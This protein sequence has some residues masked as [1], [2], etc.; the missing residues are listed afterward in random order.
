MVPRDMDIASP[1]TGRLPASLL[2]LAIASFGI[3]TTE[4]IIMGLLPDVA[5]DLG[6]SVPRAGFLVSGYAYGVAFGAPLVAI[7]TARLPR[8]GALLALMGVFVLGNLS[9][10]SA[11]TYALLMAARVLT[12]LAHG[13]F[14]GIGSVVARDLVAPHRRGRAVAVMFSGLTLANVLGVPFGTAL[15]QAMGW[16]FPF[17]VVVGIGIA[18]AGAI[19]AFVPSGLAGANGVAAEIRALREPRVLWPMAISVLSSVSLFSVFTYIAPLLEDVSGLAP[20]AVTQA[21]L[22]FGLGI[23][24]GNIA[25]GRLADWRLVETVRLAFLGVA[26]ALAALTVTSHDGTAAVVTLGVW[27]ALSFAVGA[28]LQLWVVEA[29]TEAPNLAATLNQGAFNLG[30][31]TGAWAGGVAIASGI[32]YARLPWLGVVFALVAFALTLGAR[33]GAKRVGTARPLAAP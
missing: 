20:R 25:G 21:L 18:A 5:R 14:F 11:P 30:N 9:C 15:G 12:S 13:A 29:A 19:A 4:F 28:P 32:G 26:L 3:G 17:F 1:S 8:K 31:A 2:A 24:I 22:V 10:A 23:T 16:R 33:R 7:A 27:G 6:V